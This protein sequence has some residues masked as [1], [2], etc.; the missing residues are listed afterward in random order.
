MHWL[1][2]KP[3]DHEITLANDEP[4]IATT[5]DVEWREAVFG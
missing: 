4:G 5:I 1:R 2:V 3:G